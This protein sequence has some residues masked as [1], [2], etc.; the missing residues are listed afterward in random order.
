MLGFGKMSCRVRHLKSVQKSRFL[1]TG[2]LVMLVLSACA[3]VPPVQEMSNARQSLNAAKAVQADIH[4]PQDYNKAQELIDLAS[5]HIEQ[6]EYT[7][8]RELAISAKQLAIRAR[9]QTLNKTRSET[10]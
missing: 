4:N 7:R 2:V 5:Q 9:Q 8:A 1:L 10:Q 3:I 6:G